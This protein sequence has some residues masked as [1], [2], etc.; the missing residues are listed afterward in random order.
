MPALGEQRCPNSLLVHVARTQCGPVLAHVSQQPA[1][2]LVPQN[3]DAT[4]VMLG[5]DDCLPARTKTPEPPAVL[6][7]HGLRRGARPGSLDAMEAAIAA[8]QAT[9][10]PRAS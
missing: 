10:R 7:A 4:A 6:H 1:C 2:V 9:D 3:G 5:V 8:V